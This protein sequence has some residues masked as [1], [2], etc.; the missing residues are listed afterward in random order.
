MPRSNNEAVTQ[1]HNWSSPR[2]LAPAYEP[3]ELHNQR[4]PPKLILDEEA[5]DIDRQSIDSASA[6]NLEDD[7]NLSDIL[8]SDDER[9]LRPSSESSQFS[10]GLGNPGFEEE[11]T[12]APTKEMNKRNKSKLRAQHN[13]PRLANGSAGSKLSVN[14][15]V[16]QEERKS[17]LASSDLSLDAEEKTV[18]LPVKKDKKKRQQDSE[19]QRKVK[20]LLSPSDTGKKVRRSSITPVDKDGETSKQSAAAETKK[21][22]IS[23]TIENSQDRGRRKSIS[24]TDHEVKIVTPRDKYTNGRKNSKAF[25]FENV[26]KSDNEG[27]ENANKNRGKGNE[28]L[29][30]PDSGRRKSVIADRERSGGDEKKVNER[31]T[32][33]DTHSNGRRKSLSADTEDAKSSSRND[34]KMNESLTIPV[35][36]P[37]KSLTV[38]GEAKTA[39]ER[40]TPKGNR[41]SMSVDEDEAES[42]SRNRPKINEGS[43]TPANGR[44]KSTATE[45]TKG[46]KKKLKA[47][48]ET[49]R[50][51]DDSDD[52]SDLEKEISASPQGFTQLNV[53][54][55]T[56]EMQRRKSITSG[57]KGTKKKK[58]KR[59]EKK[60]TTLKSEDSGQSDDEDVE[61]KIKEINENTLDPEEA[62]RKKKKQKNANATRRKSLNP[63]GTLQDEEINGDF[64]QSATNLKEDSLTVRLEK[65]RK[66]SLI[67][68]DME[69]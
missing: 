12:T 51:A 39:S 52:L 8:N 10:Q 56:P 24:T 17:S 57:D 34:M 5:S 1:Q 6:V 11:G 65:K 38:D 58:K 49:K 35:T 60:T 55:A 26:T 4:T 19:K 48:K 3:T 63:G 30:T 67:V 23:L 42:T 25:A 59:K 41:K 9:V 54:P 15:S 31:L 27:E 7:E 46:K 18:F 16:E 2:S 20:T 64:T 53:I 66:K 22:K 68:E 37:R 14:N 13:S 69:S 44:R 40:T 61:D 29:A 45:N 21:N 50:K 47:G 36:R 43:A 28:E 33:K 32:V 62:P